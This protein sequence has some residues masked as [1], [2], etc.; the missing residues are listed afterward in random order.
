ME[1]K[2]DLISKFEM[3][4]KAGVKAV[5]PDIEIDVQYA[6]AFDKPEKG[7]SLRQQCIKA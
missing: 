7:K 2:S 1:L 4:F 3:D 5:N 6:E